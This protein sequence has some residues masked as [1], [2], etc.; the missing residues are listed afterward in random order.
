MQTEPQVSFRHMT[1][2]DA[3]EE[4]IRERIARLEKTSDHITSCRVVVEP[5]AQHQTRGNLFHVRVHIGVP[6]E[7]I[8]VTSEPAAHTEAQDIQVALRDAFDSARRQLE[9]Y[10]RRRRGLVK[11]LEKLPH[12]RVNKLF[13]DK[14]YGF[15]ETLDG[16][17]VYFHRNSVVRE[18][19]DQLQVGSEVTFV[20]EEGDRGPQASTVKLVGRHHH[21]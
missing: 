3:V 20:E 9:D 1:H 4:I 15:I 11:A 6:G 7:E 17:E 21:V 13:S 2:S 16:R 12:A 19:F 18:G 5:A 10:V 8:V 14:G